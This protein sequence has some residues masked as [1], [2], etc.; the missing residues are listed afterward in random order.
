MFDGSNP[1][2]TSARLAFGLR[3]VVKVF[4]KPRAQASSAGSAEL[5]GA[6]L[7]GDGHD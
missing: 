6:G 2:D 4:A 5:T 7:D 1:S 3:P